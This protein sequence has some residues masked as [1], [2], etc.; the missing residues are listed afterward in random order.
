M[1]TP[2]ADTGG[3]TAG[4]SSGRRSRSRSSRRSSGAGGE[5]VASLRQHADALTRLANDLEYYYYYYYDYY[6]YY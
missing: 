1:H 2:E 3:S 6:Y 4:S 5:L